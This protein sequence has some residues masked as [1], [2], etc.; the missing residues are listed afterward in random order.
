MDEKELE[1]RVAQMTDDEQQLFKET[2]YRLA[3]CFGED[4][5]SA[6]VV[7]RGHLIGDMSE[8]MQ[9]NCNDMDASRILKG[10]REY[11]DFLHTVDAP[12]KEKFN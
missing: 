2:I 10:T 6:V 3:M 12:P 8:V 9:F 5:W 11:L 4:A 1:R 7:V